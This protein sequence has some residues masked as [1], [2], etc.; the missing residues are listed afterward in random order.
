MLKRPNVWLTQLAVY[1]QGEPPTL[2]SLSDPGNQQLLLPEDTAQQNGSGERK[3]AFDRASMITVNDITDHLRHSQRRPQD[4]VI[5][6]R[7][8]RWSLSNILKR[9]RL[10]LTQVW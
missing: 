7:T 8:N 5:Y 1:L 10:H 4:V 9:R 2:A 6:S 3:P